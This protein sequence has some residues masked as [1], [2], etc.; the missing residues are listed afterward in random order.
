MLK[1]DVEGAE[2]EVLRGAA[3]LL[4]TQGPT[5]LCEVSEASSEAVT[6]LLRSLD[7]RIF[8]GEL[9]PKDRVELRK[10]PWNTVAVRKSP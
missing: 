3:G 7:Y 1:I 6:D 9:P 8:D 4:K 10:A 5:L 2:L